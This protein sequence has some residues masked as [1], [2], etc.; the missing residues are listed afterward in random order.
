MKMTLEIL[1]KKKMKNFR[2]RE[3]SLS[4]MTSVSKQGHQSTKVLEDPSPPI[5]SLVRKKGRNSKD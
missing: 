5:F 3:Q 4:F 1:T 2:R